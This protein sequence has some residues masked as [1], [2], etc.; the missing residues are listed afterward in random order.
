[1]NQTAAHE[2]E[3]KKARL[4]NHISE[5][6]ANS[7]S[8]RECLGPS[9][10][11]AD[12]DHAKDTGPQTEVHSA[13]CPEERRPAGSLILPQSWHLLIMCQY[14]SVSHSHHLFAFFFFFD[15][16]KSSV[17]SQAWLHKLNLNFHWTFQL[18]RCFDMI[19][20]EWHSVPITHEHS[21]S[22]SHPAAVLI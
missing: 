12:Q 22:L 2:E 13:E 8:L 3:K 14:V 16:S 1:M 9:S 21:A 15:C 11:W 6:K 17:N 19:M 18:Y 5:K 10:L 4:V 7:A 20:R